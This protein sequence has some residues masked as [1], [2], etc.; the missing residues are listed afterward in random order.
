M[1]KIGW[2]GL[3]GTT[4]ESDEGLQRNFAHACEILESGH[5][6]IVAQSYDE[7]NK[8]C[9]LRD[10]CVVQV[11]FEVYGWK[12]K[13]ILIG[14]GDKQKTPWHFGC[15]KQCFGYFQVLDDLRHHLL[16][17]RK[18]GRAQGLNH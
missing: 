3:S 11:D 7:N 17:V 14:R 5:M 6:M 8:P 1:M 13:E 18:L 2:G 10:G 4:S 16:H 9:S 15:S 12:P